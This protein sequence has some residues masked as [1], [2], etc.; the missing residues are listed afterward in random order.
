V[1]WPDLADTRGRLSVASLDQ[2]LPHVGGVAVLSAG[3]DGATSL[4]PE[5][6]TAVLDAGERG[7]DLV[8]VDLPRQVDQA[9]EVVLARADEALLVS[10]NRVRSTAAAARIA[11][12]LQSRCASVGLVLRADA[13]GVS[14]DAVRAALSVPIV[15]TLPHAPSLASRA[16]DGE[17]PS[18]RDA[19]GRACH[20]ALR[21]MATTLARV[22]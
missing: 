10:A 16:D 18:L 15:A 7:F 21:T 8:V 3:R 11:E 17:P 4:S 1:R 9:G 13:K 19:Y 20:A 2:A 14:D 5:S 6:L 12:L 22:A